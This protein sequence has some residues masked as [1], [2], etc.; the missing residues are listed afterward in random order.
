V[1]GLEDAE[2]RTIAFDPGKIAGG[3][4]VTRDAV[5]RF[6]RP[7]EAHVEAFIAPDEP[8]D[9]NPEDNQLSIQVV[10]TRPGCTERG[11]RGNAIIEDRRNR[12]VIC[13][14]NG[15]DTITAGDRD[16]VR[17]GGGRDTV[18]CRRAF[19]VLELGGG[20]DIARCP[21]ACYVDGGP[22]KDDCPKGREVI[23]EN[24]ER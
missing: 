8:P 16:V 21:G 11:G 20:N 2:P 23:R 3:D 4:K 13:T 19:C 6:V 22:G 5:F 1:G 24:C 18:T 14:R 7:T 10:V 9:R 15:D 17:S 12:Q